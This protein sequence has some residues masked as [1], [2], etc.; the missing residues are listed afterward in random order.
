MPFISTQTSAPVEASRGIVTGSFHDFIKPLRKAYR[1]P[2]GVHVDGIISPVENIHSQFITNALENGIQ[3]EDIR[4]NEA[5]KFL[6]TDISDIFEPGDLYFKSVENGNNSQFQAA[7]SFR[8]M[9]VPLIDYKTHEDTEEN[10]GAMLINVAALASL[11]IEIF[12]EVEKRE[13]LIVVAQPNKDL[14]R[15]NNTALELRWNKLLGLVE[16]TNVVDLEKRIKNSSMV[17]FVLE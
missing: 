11:P 1:I 10:V 9:H 5:V 8:S 17:Y 16:A 12:S 7:L 3:A 15:K 2:H 4:V 13:S 14:G 6:F